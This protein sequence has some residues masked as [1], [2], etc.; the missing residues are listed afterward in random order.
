MNECSVNAFPRPVA[1]AA[2]VV[3]LGFSGGAHATVERGMTDPLTGQSWIRATTLEE[4]L[5]LGY[6][7]AS[8]AEFSTYLRDGGYG[9]ESPTQEFHAGSVPSPLMG[10]AVNTSLPVS[11]DHYP[12][13]NPSVAMGWLNGQPDMVGALLYT[14]FGYTT[15]CPGN[16][17]PSCVGYGQVNE[18]VA[19]YGTLSEMEAGQHDSIVWSSGGGNSDWASALA[20]FRQ[21]GGSYSLAY[22]MV[23]GA[24]PEP[25]SYAL[26]ALGLAGIGL[27][28]RRSRRAAAH[29]A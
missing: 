3:A 17:S 2:L 7:A 26:M 12:Y 8:T 21:S 23:S 20:K 28:A 27:A 15:S 18:N 25:S 11:P 13:Q 24:V 14:W 22:F 1:T 29:A 6:R 19:A 9:A 4:G 5:A 10:F 16:G